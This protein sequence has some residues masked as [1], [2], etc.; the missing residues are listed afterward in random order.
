MNIESILNNSKYKNIVNLINEN[1][2][3]EVNIDNTQNNQ[4][5]ICLISNDII[6]KKF[7]IITLPCN[8]T[9]DYVNLYNEIY[10]QKY[11][12]YKISHIP[13]NCFR[14]PYCRKLYNG[15]IPY[16]EIDNIE[17]IKGING[18]PTKM[19]NLYNCDY[20]YKSGKNKNNK[21][22][23]NANKY[24]NG[25]YCVKHYKQ[26]ILTEIKKEE[27]NKNKE[28]QKLCKA[29]LK[30]GINK[31]KICNCVIKDKTEELY[32]KKHLKLKLND[33]KDSNK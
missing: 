27:K 21:C 14:C 12:H 26:L 7:N 2:E 17:H 4:S 28:N 33:Y 10:N 30:N 32:C 3:K 1:E 15:L 5:N 6:S 22:N 23:C 29:I 18:P 25:N 9:F 11:Y 8:H 13:S 24:K 31:G 16:F 20:I 19:L